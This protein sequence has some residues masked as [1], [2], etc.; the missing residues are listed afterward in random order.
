[1]YKALVLIVSNVNKSFFVALC[2]S[3]LILALFNER[4]VEVCVAGR[5]MRRRKDSFSSCL[6]C[7]CLQGRTLG[8][9]VD[10]LPILGGAGKIFSM[11]SLPCL[12][13]ENEVKILLSQSCL[14]LCDLMDYNLPGSSVLEILQIRIL[15]WVSIPFSR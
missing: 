8:L 11:I 3:Q 14:T 2:A 9:E 6:L 10:Y 15:E 12:S 7:C 5:R 4:E 13:Y 1:M